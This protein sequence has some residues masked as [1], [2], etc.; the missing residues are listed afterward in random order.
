MFSTLSPRPSREG[1][2]RLMIIVSRWWRLAFSTADKYM[3]NCW[4]CMR[5]GFTQ[6]EP[7][8]SCSVSRSYSVYTWLWASLASAATSSP[9]ISARPC[10]ARDVVG[11]AAGAAAGG[12]VCCAADVVCPTGTASGRPGALLERSNCR[13]HDCPLSKPEPAAT[14]KGSEGPNDFCD[15]TRRPPP[16]RTPRGGVVDLSRARI[17]TPDHGHTRGGVPSRGGAEGGCLCAPR[18]RFM[19]SS[20]ITLRDPPP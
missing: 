1:T 3:P 15:D 9:T 11:G 10:W 18:R 6:P 2:S 14:L 5:G 19:A 16:S 4:G 12:A 20:D 17:L 8:G 7:G 13:S